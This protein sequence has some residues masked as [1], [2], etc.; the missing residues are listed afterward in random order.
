[1]ADLTLTYTFITKVKYENKTVQVN[2]EVAGKDFAA[3]TYFV[4]VFNQKGEMVSK[5]SFSL[6]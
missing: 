2:E 4:N 6:R 1:V 3:G 5:T